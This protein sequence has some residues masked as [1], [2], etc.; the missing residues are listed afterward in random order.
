[1]SAKSVMYCCENSAALA[2]ELVRDGELL[3]QFEV[4]PLPCSGRIESALLL[5]TLERG[6]RGV[7]LLGCPE[8]NCKYVTGNKHAAGRVAEVRS[9]LDGAGLRG[10]RVMMDYVSSVDFHKVEGA[11]RAMISR[12][13]PTNVPE[14]AAR[15]NS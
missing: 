3:D 10:E 13:Q 4:I 12:I 8:E 15:D 11:M 7:L 9:I 2:V 1:M 6:Y 5:K 14:G